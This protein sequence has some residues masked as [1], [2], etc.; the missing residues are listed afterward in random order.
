MGDA[1][2]TADKNLSADAGACNTQK[3]GKVIVH[4]KSSGRAV[5]GGGIH[6]IPALALTPCFLQFDDDAHQAG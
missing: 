2:S 3:Q 4:G 1:D 5:S 6:P